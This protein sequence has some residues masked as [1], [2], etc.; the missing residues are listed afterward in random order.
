MYEE[1]A[2]EARPL[3][4]DGPRART[5]PRHEFC[6]LDAPLAQRSGSGSGT[7]DEASL[8]AG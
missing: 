6:V 8:A 5:E 4:F 1:E 7:Y 3:P 2:T